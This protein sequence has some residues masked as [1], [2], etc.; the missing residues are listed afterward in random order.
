MSERKDFPEPEPPYKYN[1]LTRIL[2]E[3]ENYLEKKL[4]NPFFFYYFCYCS[5]T[6]L[7]YALG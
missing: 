1:P 3:V 2:L 7:N 5:N 6:F 4:K